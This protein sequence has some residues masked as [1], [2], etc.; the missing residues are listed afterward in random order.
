MVRRRTI[1]ARTL[2]RHI[3]SCNNEDDLADMALET[4]RLELE[5]R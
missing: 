1:I 5:G 4:P 3:A 2:F